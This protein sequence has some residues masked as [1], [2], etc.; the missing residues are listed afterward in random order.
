MLKSCILMSST[1]FG[2][3]LI[4]E[5]HCPKFGRYGR[6]P[7]LAGLPQVGWPDTMIF[8]AQTSPAGLQTMFHD[9]LTS[10]S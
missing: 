4:P 9:I 3:Y 6:N 7:R 10:T 5:T 1:S 2:D 8:H